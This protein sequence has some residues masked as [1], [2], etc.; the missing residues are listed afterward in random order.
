MTT[1]LARLALLLT[2]L[3]SACSTGDSSTEARNTPEPTAG[4]VAAVP[5]EAATNVPAPTEAVATPS[6]GA[7]TAETAAP[8]ATAPATST[9]AATDTAAP[10]VTARAERSTP[11]AAQDAAFDRIARA[12]SRYRELPIKKDIREGYLSKEQLKVRLRKDFDEEYPAA[13]ARADERVLR[14]FGLIPEGTDLRKL[15]LD[16]YGEQIAGFYEPETDEMYIISSGGAL[17]ALEETTYA[18]E[19]VHALQDQHYDLEK[20]RK[21]F[22]DKNDDSLLAVT[23]LVEG[24]AELTRGLYVRNDADLAAK[25]AEIRASELPSSRILETAPP[26]ISR[27]LIFPYESGAIFN[28]S[29]WQKGGWD[30]VD[31]A[32]GD[33]PIST[34][35]I[36]HPEKYA[37][38]RDEPT[39][40]TLPNLAPALGSGWKRL[41]EN[42]F[43]EFQT[44]V[45]LEGEEGAGDAR[46]AA[47]GWDG[48]RFALYA[49]GERDVVAWRSAWDGEQDAEQFAGALRA[50]DEA[51][52]D[53]TYGEQDGVLRLADGERVALIRRDGD[54][55][56]Y[57]LAPDEGLARKALDELTAVG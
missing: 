6:P 54:R 47:E 36:L 41:E 25:I 8:A 22:E 34:E 32:Y 1:A 42:L 10:T 52:F 18:H 5:T 51:R 13:E 7:D 27:S 3:L 48:D 9:P 26:I 37:D 28:V 2:L 20:L 30:A 46:Q 23:A 50:Y 12:T 49:N 21:P 11:P 55:V 16:L 14:A 19:V 43:G 45:L 24:D 40:I 57:V 31:R 35:Q 29:L 4:S 53:T 17:N 38:Q 44:A 56:S 15:Y 39:D 33:P